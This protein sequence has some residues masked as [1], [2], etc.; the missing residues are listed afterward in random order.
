MEAQTD[1][2]REWS[3]IVLSVINDV[4]FLFV[5]FACLLFL[6][7]LFLLFFFIM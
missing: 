2:L 7:F 4:C 6:F 1:E 3:V 5:L